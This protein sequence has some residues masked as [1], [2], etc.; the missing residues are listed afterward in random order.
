MRKPWTLIGISVLMAA[1]AVATI[2]C[3][4]SSKKSRFHNKA[5]KVLGATAA[6]LMLI[7]IRNALFESGF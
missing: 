7:L 3:S 6:P 4:S 2:A 5:T 1:L